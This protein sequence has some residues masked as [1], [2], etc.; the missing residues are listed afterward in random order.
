MIEELVDMLPNFQGPANRSRC[1]LHTVNLIAKTLLKQFDVPR[2]DASAVLDAAERELLDLAAGLDVEE[3][4]TV[5]ENGTGDKFDDDNVDGWV[6]E[7][8]ELTEEEGD[9]LRKQIRPVQLVLVKVNC[10][11]WTQKLQI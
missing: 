8:A 7:M 2:K 4:M 6:D 3:L 10:S 1:F 11:K 9:E 5:A